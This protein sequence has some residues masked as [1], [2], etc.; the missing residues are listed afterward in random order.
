MHTPA[1]LVW[2]R[3]RKAEQHQATLLPSRKIRLHDGREFASPSGA[4][5]GAADVVSYDGRYAWRLVSDGRTL[6]QLR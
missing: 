4:A 2:N 3:P 5:M 6:N 1:E